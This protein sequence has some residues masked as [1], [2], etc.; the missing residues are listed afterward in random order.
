MSLEVLHITTRAGWSEAQ[1]V[2]EVRPIGGEFVHC[3]TREQLPATLER[4]FAGA[5]ALVVLVLDR[6]ALGDSLRWEESRPGE[7][8]PHVYAPIP[9][10][11]VTAV[12]RV[13]APGA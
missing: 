11:A 10:S 1:Q 4:H 8:F 12:E 9:V 6:A 2:G 13:T 5:G 7:A 3:S